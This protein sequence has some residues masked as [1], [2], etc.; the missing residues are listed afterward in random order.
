VGEGEG[1]GV[2]GQ[3]SKWSDSSLSVLKGRGITLAVDDQ[4]GQSHLLSSS[5]ASGLFQP[6]AN[7]P[8]AGSDS[9]SVYSEQTVTGPAVGGNLRASHPAQAQVQMRAIGD[10]RTPYGMF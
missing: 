9:P 1:K 2:V 3:R 5:M 4:G 10:S 8:Q 6:A 7:A